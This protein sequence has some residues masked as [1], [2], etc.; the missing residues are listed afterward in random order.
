MKKLLFLVATIALLAAGCNELTSTSS[1]EVFYPEPT[2][3]VIDNAKILDQSTIDKLTTDL[4]AF[5]STAQIA[6]VTVPSVEPVGIEEYG[7]KLAE[8]FKPGYEGKDNGIIFIIAY[9]D[10]KMRI[11]VGRGLEE[12][13]TDTEAAHILDD[14]VKPLFKASK[15][16]EGVLAGVE[17]IKAGVQ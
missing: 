9:N 1:T 5:D 10:H 6:V 7:I 2:G 13:L 17:A 4:T 14:V 16:N 11:E 3:Y 12:K 15:Y 8:K